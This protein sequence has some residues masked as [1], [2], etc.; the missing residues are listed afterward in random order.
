MI[1]IWG[2]LMLIFLFTGTN[3]VAQNKEPKK[4]IFSGEITIVPLGTAVNSKFAEYHPLITADESVMYF[5]SRRDS[6]LGRQKDPK[7]D[8]YYE[9]IYISEKR[10]GEWQSPRSIGKPVNSELHDAAVGLSPDGQKMFL[11]KSGD[12]Y[13]SELDGDKWLNP[14]KLSKNINSKYKESTA[15]YSYTG[16][17]MYFVSN[18]PDGIGQNDI[19]LSNLTEKGD[20]GKPHNLGSEINTA[21]NEDAVFMHPDGKTIYFSSQGHETLGGYDIFSSVYDDKTGRWSTPENLGKPIN[22]VGDDVFFVL[23]AS[24]KR[25]YYSSIREGG[26]G[27]KDIYVIN[28]KETKARPQLTL[29]KGTITNELGHPVEAKIEIIDNQTKEV[30]MS[31]KSNKTSGRY[32]FSLPSGRNYGITITADEYFFH[33]EHIDIPESE[34]YME[35]SNSIKLKPAD[36]G[37][38]IVLN[39][40]FFD[41]DKAAL[42][43]ESK[44]ELG[45]AIKLMNQNPKL[46][47]EI[48]GHTDDKG[49]EAYNLDLSERRAEAVVN[50]LIE[51]GIAKSRLVHAGYGFNRPIATNDTEAGRKKNRRVEMLIIENIEEKKSIEIVFK[52]QILASTNRFPPGSDRFGGAKDVQEY[53]HK[54]MYKYTV[55][56]L[57]NLVDAKQL[58]LEMEKQGFKEAFVVAFYEDKRIAM[59]T[60]LKLLEH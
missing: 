45:R 25:G 28:M 10:D 50:Y 7:F 15:C 17:T 36:V 2:L 39:Y 14:V 42:K 18:R 41:Y 9:D 55:G 56:K 30:L 53:A 3:V 60:A 8:I 33:S 57:S 6:T 27:E 43:P 26:S 52:V 19:Y 21:L 40:L 5:T 13:E 23:A 46:L 58:E 38:S 37:E 22:T 29:V 48:S 31:T 11:Y 20:W 4:D 44:T 1:R 49:S 34:P 59:R 24:G 16:K 51:H 35:L 12:I 47:F 32:L 54:G